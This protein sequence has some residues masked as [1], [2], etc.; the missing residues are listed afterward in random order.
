[1][2]SEPLDPEETSKVSTKQVY[3]VPVLSTYGRVAELTQSGT[4]PASENPGAN[5]FRKP[6]SREMKENISRV[7]THPLGFGL[8]LF[9]YR[10]EFQ[11]H[12]G[13]GRQFGVMIDEVVGVVPE[14]VCTNE[15]GYS[16]VDY[17]MLGISHPI[18]H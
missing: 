18:L 3:Q 15:N 9:D 14:A 5:A 10:P 7:G 1:M 16:V 17:A 6:S 11:S 8:Y 2:Y 12:A 13:Y 4:A